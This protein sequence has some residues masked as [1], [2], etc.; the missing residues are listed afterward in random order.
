MSW[1]QVLK[2]DEVEKNFR[3]TLSNVADKVIPNREH[4]RNQQAFNNAVMA[5]DKKRQS[6]EKQLSDQRYKEWL[7]SKPTEF[8]DDSPTKSPS[9]GIDLAAGQLA[10]SNN[11]RLRDL[12]EKKGG[13]MQV[14]NELKLKYPDPP[15]SQFFSEEGL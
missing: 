2:S 8:P 12:W 15:R 4:N 3:Q 5:Q 1:F 10:E 9:T 7:S 6:E 11:W 13:R 14:F